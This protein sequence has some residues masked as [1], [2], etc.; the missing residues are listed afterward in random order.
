MEHISEIKITI[1]EKCKECKGCGYV[2]I[3]DPEYIQEA[4]CSECKGTGMVKKEITLKE[5]KDLLQ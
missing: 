4:V 3:Q 2:E 1:T 5:L